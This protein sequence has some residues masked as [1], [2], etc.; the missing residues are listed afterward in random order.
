MTEA[1][2]RAAHLDDRI[3]LRMLHMR[4]GGKAPAEIGASFGWSVAR[5]VGVTDDVR[6][7]DLAE[8]GEDRHLVASAYWGAV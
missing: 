3:V 8:S 1:P 4:A 7:A 2:D 6:A 5:V